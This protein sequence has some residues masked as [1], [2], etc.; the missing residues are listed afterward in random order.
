MKAILHLILKFEW[1][2]MIERGEKSE[3]YR[4]ITPNYTKK[5]FKDGQ[6]R[7]YHA[8]CFHRGYSNT[9]MLRQ[10]KPPRVGRGRPEWGAPNRDVYILDVSKEAKP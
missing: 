9:T 2:D 10:Y 5:F 3:E 6:P 7:N 4:D 1:Y 8:I